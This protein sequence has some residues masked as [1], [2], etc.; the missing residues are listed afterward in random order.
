[1]S[2]LRRLV[3]LALAAAGL[4]TALA[5]PAAAASANPDPSRFPVRGVDVTEYQHP[6]GAAVNWAQIR[7]SGIAFATLKATRGT[8]KT[9]SYFA[10]DLAGALGQGIPTAPYHYLTGTSSNVAAQAD[11]FIGALRNAGYTGNRANELPPILDL[12]WTDDG[13]SSC[14]PYTT[15]P[16]VQEFLDRVQSAF[17]VKPW[18]YTSRGFMSSCMGNT[19]AFGSYG[20]QVADYTSGRTLPSVPSGWPTWLMWQ[21]ADVG[22]V[23][24][25]PT[26]NVTL[27]VF[28]G[29][30]ADLDALVRRDPPR[31]LVDPQGGRVTDFDGDGRPDILGLGQTGDD[32]W[33]IPNT[34]SSGSPSRGQS[35]LVSTGWRT[36][37]KYWLADYD[38]DG[39]TDILGTQDP[40]KLFVW[41][42]TSTPGN[43]SVAP[44]VGLGTAWNTLAKLVIGDFTG[45]GKV[46]IGGVNA[47]TGD[48]FWVVP[49]TSTPGNPSRGQ[50]IPMTTGWSTVTRFWPAD[51]DRDGKTDLL[52][53]QGND[54]LFAWRNTASG[55][56]PSFAPLANLG[57]GWSTLT[58]LVLGDFTGDGKVDI[59]G[60]TAWNA[61]Q[62]YVVPNTSSGTTLS[63]GQSV[64]MSTGWSSITSYLVADYDGDGKTDLLGVQGTDQML[65]WRG[66]HSGG[67]PGFTALT[68][69][70]TGWNTVGHIPT[71]Q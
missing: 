16:F 25:V 54:Q 31:P 38:G 68:S 22:S 37:T 4:A 70:G 66:T 18:I 2:S 5:Q 62:L 53:L 41:R 65:I 14:P 35:K 17:G 27:N 69:L 21:Y 52:G 13:T 23:P 26:T 32:L 12:E 45:D 57:T 9:N 64:P 1:M 50:S 19:T 49:N 67:T 59:A 55:G 58:K 28:N 29:S 30:Q 51:W 8:N 11:F 34:S 44:L 48:Q 47:S 42:N 43:P 10:S 20:L 56:V 46:D 15:V 6:N 36:I 24:G 60:W 40:D 63:R 3:A 61:D 33:F 7:Q 71:A 39:K